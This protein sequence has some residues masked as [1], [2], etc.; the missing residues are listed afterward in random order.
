MKPED[1]TSKN[2]VFLPAWNE[3][4]TVGAVVAQIRLIHPDFDVLVVDDGSS[5]STHEFARNAGAFV[6]RLPVNLGVGGAIKCALRYASENSYT[7]LFQ[8]DADGQHNPS[9]LVE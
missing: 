3:E 4:R 6:I 9:Y 8:I 2:L 7:N 1:S 5:D